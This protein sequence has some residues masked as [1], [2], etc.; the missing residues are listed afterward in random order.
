MSSLKIEG[1]KCDNIDCS[2][3]DNTVTLNQYE[4]YLNK[5]CPECSSNLLTEAD[6][7]SVKIMIALANNPVVK[8]IDKICGLL[9]SK[10]ETLEVEMNGSGKVKLKKNKD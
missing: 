4:S 8:A 2:Y 5:P 7:K 6:L 1:L 3:E 9:G 10:E